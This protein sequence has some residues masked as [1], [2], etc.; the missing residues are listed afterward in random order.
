MGKVEV[1]RM[2]NRHKVPS[3]IVGNSG[4]PN[5]IRPPGSVARRA[6]RVA[7][8]FS[9]GSILGRTHGVLTHLGKAELQPWAAS[10]KKSPAKGQELVARHRIHKREKSQNKQGLEG[11]STCREAI[12][13][14]RRSRGSL[15]PPLKRELDSRPTE[16]HFSPTDEEIAFIS[17]GR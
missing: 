5:P 17:H 11:G 6:S 12:D 9:D 14:S 7:I 8:W 15:D 13:F 4:Q 2:E 1:H 10:G 16:G 3:G